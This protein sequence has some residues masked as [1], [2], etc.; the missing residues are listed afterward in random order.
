MAWIVDAESHDSLLPIGAVGELVLEG[1]TLARG[2]IGEP[3]KTAAAF[4]EVAPPWLR[5]LRPQSRLYKTGDLVRYNPDGTIRFIGRK[6]TQVKIRGQRV[7]LG[8]VEH[9]IRAL[10]SSSIRDVIAEVVRYEQAGPRLAVFVHHSQDF[11]VADRG[12]FLRP[13]EHNREEA[14]RVTSDLQDRLPKYMIPDMWIP[15]STI[16][17]T[18]NG[19][20]DRRLLRETLAGLNKSEFQAY[21]CGSKAGASGG[22]RPETL[23]EHKLVQVVVEVLGFDSPADLGI[24]DNFFTLGGDSIVAM[25]LVDRARLRGFTFRVT[26]VFRTPALSALARF[27]ADAVAPQEVQQIHD[28]RGDLRTSELV[29]SAHMDEAVQWWQSRGQYSQNIEHVLPL[30]EAAEQYFFQRPRYWILSIQGTLDT[31]RLQTA[32]TALVRRHGTLRS[33]FVHQHKQVLQLILQEIDT[34]IEYCRTTGSMADFVDRYRRNDNISVPS[35]NAP[36]TRFI[37]VQRS[38]TDQALVVRL[39]HAQYDGYCLH[40]LWRDLKQLYEAVS[41]PDAPSYSHHMRQW[42]HSRT[43]EAFDFWR[44]TLRDAVIPRI[45]NDLPPK[46]LCN[47]G[48]GEAPACEDD[49]GDDNTYVSV[50]QVVS[51]PQSTPKHGITTATIVKAAWGILLTKLTGSESAVFAQGSSGRAYGAQDVVGMCLNFIPVRSDCASGR[52]I[53]ELLQSLQTQHVESLAHELTDFRDIVQRSTSW[54][55]QTDYQSVVVHQ[56][57]EPDRPF[58]FGEAQAQVTCSFEWS[59]PPKEI[60]IESHPKDTGELQ[61]DMDTDTSVLTSENAR[62]VLKQFCR[63]IGVV[64]SAAR[65]DN[66]ET[67]AGVMAVLDS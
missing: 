29:D 21:Q 36:V 62:V 18:T 34:N 8:E 2:Y 41:L 37:M 23:F 52:L 27:H 5:K 47:N 67:V 7:E 1:H 22:R 60:H 6:D 44:K 38:E 65:D 51:L 15:L 9:H 43:E 25:R 16:P 12:L 33:A 48:H 11:S 39:N 61:V 64:S 4:L 26:D 20:H 24:D 3:E 40:I 14:L 30:T 54:P 57:I 19:K 35:L 56:N 42:A 63:L 17:T 58:A 66:G 13:T 10:G 45:G 46:E 55:A 59:R 32:C 49:G 28:S 53:S 50:S 31:N